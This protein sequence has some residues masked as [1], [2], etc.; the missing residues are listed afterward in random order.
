MSEL[1]LSPRDVLLPFYGIRDIWRT[2]N[3]RL[4]PLLNHLPL[5]TADGLLSAHALVT[6]L[7]IISIKLHKNL[8]HGWIIGGSETSQ[9]VPALDCCQVSRLVARGLLEG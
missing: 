4:F 5:A 6:G 1:N 3:K 8:Q 7:L 9:G 2:F